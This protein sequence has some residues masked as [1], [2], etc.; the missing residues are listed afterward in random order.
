M[1]SKKLIEYLKNI[2]EYKDLTLNDIVDIYQKDQDKEKERIRKIRSGL[3]RF[4]KSP[5]S[6][7]VRK[8]Y[9]DYMKLHG[10]EFRARRKN[11]V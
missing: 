11:S 3:K 2:D 10:G 1:N 8:Q 4:W 6:D 7:A 9:S 5:E